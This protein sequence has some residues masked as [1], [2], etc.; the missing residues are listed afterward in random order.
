MTGITAGTISVTNG[1]AAITGAGTA[2]LWAGVRANSAMVIKA[3]AGRDWYVVGADATSDTAL[4][5]SEAYAGASESG[6][7][8]EIVPVYGT[9][10][11]VDALQQMRRVV[12]W[13]QDTPGLSISGVAFVD[14][15]AGRAAYDDED[16]GFVVWVRDCTGEDEGAGRAATYHMGGGGSADWS[17][18]AWITGP[19]GATGE[20][21]GIGDL[22]DVTVTAPAAGDILRHDGA[23]W[24]NDTPSGWSPLA[25]VAG[26]ATPDFDDGGRFLLTVDED[27]ALQLP[28]NPVAG[29]P[30]VLRVVMSGSHEF[31]FASGWLGALPA[32]LEGDGD[33]TILSGLVLDTA[34]TTA[35]VNLVKTIPA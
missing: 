7:A 18:P 28:A 5:L 25:V 22:D 4:T 19:K 13:M 24:I 30:F 8:Y 9:A 11:A 12:R 3:T 2:W 16:E 31:T 23:G 1:S 35:V 20:V 27:C 32:V 29:A 34:P 21:A 17:L 14:D 33:E 10:D 15:I 26:E 6:V